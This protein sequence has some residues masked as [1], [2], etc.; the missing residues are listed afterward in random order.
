MNPRNQGAGRG[1]DGRPPLLLTKLHPPPRRDQ[2]IVRDRL[3][4][5]LRAGPGIK[6]TVVAAP[7]GSG[8]STLLGAWRELEEA[9]RPV[10]WLTLDEGDNDPVVLWSYVLAALRGALPNLEVSASPELIG[11]S[12]VVDLL[13]PEL[14]NELT[15][16]GEAA[17]VLDDFHLL[18]S[19]PA[20]ES[21]AWFIEHAPTTFR[22]VLATRSE[23][24]LPLAALRAHAAL[25]ELRAG[26]LAFTRGE[27][28]SLLNDRLDLGLTLRSIDGLVERT[29]GWAAGLYLAGLSLHAAD[30]RDAFATRFGAESRNVVDFLLDE[31]LAAHDPG[32]QELMLRSSIL[33]RLSGPL[34]DAV[35][36]Q[37]GTGRVLERLSRVN[38]FLLPLDEQGQWYRF[39]HLF[40][41]LLRV[42]LEHREPGLALELHRRASAWYRANGSVDAAIEHA[43]AA[44]GFDE[45]G[46]LIGAAW[47]DYV[48]VGRHATVLGWLD[49]LPGEC[50]RD[51]SHLQLVAAWIQALCGNHRASM[52]AA[53]AVERIGGLDA[54]PLKDGFNSLEASLATVRGLL[55]GRGDLGAA[56]TNARRAAELEGP[57][58]PRR[59]IVCF[60]L[61]T[62]LYH[63]SEL[64]EA[65]LWLGEA[66]ELAPSRRHWRVG[67]ASLAL[68]SLI[69]G[70]QGRA[71]EQIQVAM[72]AASLAR[73]HGLE[74]VDCEVL[75]ALA[76]ALDQQG[77]HNEALQM[78][79]RAAAVARAAGHPMSL[80]DT[81]IRQAAAFGAAGM[82][83]D[84]DKAIAEARAILDS[85]ADPRGLA[86]RLAALEHPRPTHRRTNGTELSARELVVL[87]MLGGSLSERDIGRELYLSHSTIHSH[88]KSIYRK[89]GV[90]SRP[91]ALEH[92]RELGII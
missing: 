58:S 89:L 77:K 45:V 2:T 74:S 28:D 68:R 65:E 9:T 46:G 32:T 88:T 52:E 63:S 1:S 54:G 56:I 87:R 38:L 76:C 83:E 4:D 11:A 36:E 25:L 20:R 39:H 80:A 31:V 18:S 49:R 86:K 67:A 17:L 19:G 91:D 66:S 22:P 34:C 71:D 14:L 64:D 7:A 55:I 79:E 8:K 5:R 27:A 15:E 35:L 33:D 70:D 82:S 30:D 29:E 85:S 78:F 92:A 6:L 50:V 72:D 53:A 16:Q 61:G 57:Q 81:L 62:C 12:R 51:D 59:A 84:G 42:E 41:R 75:V 47:L 13:L 48:R 90:S 60:V 37:E 21:V 40:A 69:A 44:G 23:P 3:L 26:D 24:A 10:A 43:L 73:E